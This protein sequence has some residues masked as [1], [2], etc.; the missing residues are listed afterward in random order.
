VP[1]F[2]HLAT[3]WAKYTRFWKEKIRK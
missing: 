2:C 3:K 1:K